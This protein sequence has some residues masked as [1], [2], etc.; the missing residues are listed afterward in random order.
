MFTIYKRG[1]GVAARVSVGVALLLI[2]LFAAY[3]LHGALINLPGLGFDIPLVGL[4]LS[5][6]LVWSFVFFLFLLF[7]IA[8]LVGFVETG[9]SRID[10]IGRGVVEYLIDT[11]AELK[12]V[13]WP[14]KNE[15]IG[16]TIV[17]LICGFVMGVYVFG[18]D[19]LVTEVMR[20]LNI[21]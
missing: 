8:L 18:V 3:S 16:S 7:F 2:A 15:L 21:L 20:L 13:S 14:L 12:K 10:N 17:V 5:W 6:G 11:Q 19:R 1:L 4:P 9:V